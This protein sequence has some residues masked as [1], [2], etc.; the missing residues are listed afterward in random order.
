MTYC[1]PGSRNKRYR[2]ETSSLNTALTLG[3]L[4]MRS[5]KNGTFPSFPFYFIQLV[6]NLKFDY[7]VLKHFS[8]FISF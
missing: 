1:E 5:H 6:K 2:S 7:Y 8:F 3:P 4:Q